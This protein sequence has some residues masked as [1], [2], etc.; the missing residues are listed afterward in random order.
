M[1][2]GRRKI[3]LDRGDTLGGTVSLLLRDNVSSTD[4]GGPT[5]L[6]PRRSSRP[7]LKFMIFTTVLFAALVAI[8]ALFPEAGDALGIPSVA[9]TWDAI[10]ARIDRLFP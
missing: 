8:F 9:D 3:K 1:P 4:G 2:R 7:I 5:R 6:G 10:A